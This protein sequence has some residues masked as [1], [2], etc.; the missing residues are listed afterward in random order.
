MKPSRSLEA[1]L[2]STSGLKFHPIVKDLVEQGSIGMIVGPSKGRKSML[3][4]NLAMALVSGKPFLGK[5]TFGPKIGRG[6]ELGKHRVL[7][8]DFELTDMAV[9]TRARVMLKNYDADPRRFNYT[10]MTDF[11]DEEAQIMDVSSKK[12]NRA[13]FD[14]LIAEIRSVRATVVV[15]DCLYLIVGEENDNALMTAAL[16]E[17]A[18]VRNETGATVVIVHHTKKDRPDYKEPFQVGRGASSI[19]GFFEWVLAI[20]PKSFGSIEATLHHGS[21]NFRGVAPFPAMFDEAFLVWRGEAEQSPDDVVGA[22]M[23]DK[24]EMPAPAFYDAIKDK[25]GIPPR[26]AARLVDVCGNYERIKAHRGQP[27]TIRL[28]VSPLAAALGEGGGK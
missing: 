12:A 24:H 26:Q 22:V 16:R 8:L 11:L 3:A 27:A 4:A 10:F 20:E 1:I 18:R 5:P 9:A 21:R 13:F 19:G 23:G 7:Y 15:I 17:I 28:R 6:E 2:K 25:A 14:S